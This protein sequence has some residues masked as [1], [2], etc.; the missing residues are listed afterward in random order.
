[1]R[2]TITG[3]G[4]VFDEVVPFSDLN[5]AGSILATA[6]LAAL[7]D[8]TQ[9][10]F[11]GAL[12]DTEPGADVAAITSA[13]ER[14]GVQDPGGTGGAIFVSDQASSAR[15]VSDAMRPLAVAI[16]VAAA[17]VAFVAL[18][19]VGQAVARTSREPSSETDALRALGTSTNERV[20]F[21]AARAGLVGVGGAI[22]AVVVAVALSG[23]FPI[24]VARV[25]EP[26]PGVR[27][28]ARVLVIGAAVIVVVTVA[29]SL[30]AALRRS[31]AELPQARPSRLAAAA[32]ARGLSPAAVQGVRFAARG[33]DTRTVPMRST[34]LAVTIAITAV[35]ATVTFAESLGKLID[36]PSRYGQ[37]WD[38]LVDAQ[39][40]PAPVSRIV[41][42]FGM[43]PAVRGIAAG[44]YGDVVVNGAPVPAFDLVSIKGQV[45]VVIDEGRPAQTADEIVLGGET[46]DRLDVRVG[47]L[48]EVDTGEGSRPMRLTGSGVFPRMGQ[49]SFSTTGLGIGAQLGGASLVSFGDFENV[50]PDYELDGKRYN[51]VAVDLA[52]APSAR[53]REFRELETAAVADEAFAFTRTEQP[54]TKIRDLDRVR[55]VPGATAAVLALVGVAALAHLLITSVRERRREL[56]L[57]QTLGF[58][59]RQLQAS[60]RWQASV[61]ALA[62]LAIGAPLGILLG[63]AVW[64][65]F[66]DGLYTTAGAETPW[67]WLSA[68]L[69]GSVIVANLVAAPAGRAAARTRLAVV[70]RDE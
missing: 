44:N 20:V 50:P 10:N 4:V 26:V 47:D 21:T 28:D 55:V 41:E 1:M 43:D 15:Q 8:R 17:A 67:I 56:A 46:I 60:V 9:W 14:L 63:R 32:A 35:L 62:A 66:A 22:G 54:P 27:V 69:I 23:R 5:E 52:A 57:L 13:I 65:R 37:G 30:P 39:F 68:V 31:R 51:F 25:A 42:R 29:S 12:V 49:G 6:P 3:V 19:V 61:V 53:D 24:G 64:T 70:L 11:E 40:G 2:L 16:G 18:F 59:R 38:R 7:V 36:T 45:S 34:L 58:S 33:G 48:V